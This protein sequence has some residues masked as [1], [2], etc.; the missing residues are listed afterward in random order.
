[1][2]LHRMRLRDSCL[3]LLAALGALLMVTGALAWAV[4][5]G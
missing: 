5:H 3:P 2:T 4:R 1:M